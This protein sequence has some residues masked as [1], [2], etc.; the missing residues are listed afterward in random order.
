MCGAL[1]PPSS[2]VRYVAINASMAWKGIR[3]AASSS[4]SPSSPSPPSPS[5]AC[6]LASMTNGDA[7]NSGGNLAARMLRSTSKS[8]SSHDEVRN[9]APGEGAG[10]VLPDAAVKRGGCTVS[11]AWCTPKSKGT[12]PDIGTGSAGCSHDE[13][14]PAREGVTVVSMATGSAPVVPETVAGGSSHPRPRSPACAPAASKREGPGRPDAGG[15]PGAPVVWTSPSGGFGVRGIDRLDDGECRAGETQY[16]RRVALSTPGLPP[17][18]RLI[19]GNAADVVGPCPGGSSCMAWRTGVDRAPSGPYLVVNPATYFMC[20]CSDG[21][22]GLTDLVGPRELARICGFT[23]PVFHGVV[24]VS[25][26]GAC[27]RN[28]YLRLSPAPPKWSKLRRTTLETR[29]GALTEI[30]NDRLLASGPE[31]T[32]QVA[33]LPVV[34]VPVEFHGNARRRRDGCRTVHMRFEWSPAVAQS[35]GRS[36]RR[37]CRTPS[38]TAFHSSSACLLM[39]SR[40]SRSAL[41]S[42]SSVSL[43]AWLAVFRTMA[44]ASFARV[45]SGGRTRSWSRLSAEFRMNSC[46]TLLLMPHMTRCDL[47]GVFRF[48]EANR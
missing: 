19:T 11:P 35:S 14:V 43:S 22:Q 47:A 23:D 27:R 21:F 15:G 42:S 8:S 20:G 34:G 17:A 10:A 9:G 44:Y 31:A 16:A 13:D 30:H 41:A 5:S 29:S 38:A 12:M 36:G 1:L 48:A 26:L 39:A 45:Q 37:R 32:G 24:R 40:D 6:T 33:Q 4:T 7:S 18:V 25:R 2:V 46:W 28:A 3:P